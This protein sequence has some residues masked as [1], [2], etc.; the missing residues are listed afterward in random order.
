M[1]CPT[2]GGTLASLHHT[3]Q[4]ERL[5]FYCPTCRTHGYGTPEALRWWTRA[6]WAAWIEGTDEPESR[7]AA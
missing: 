6:E 2:C 5:H 3:A 4:R 1:T 7:S